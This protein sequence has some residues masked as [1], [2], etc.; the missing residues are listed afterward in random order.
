MG[1]RN[2]S[3]GSRQSLSLIV[4][5]SI[6]LVIICFIGINRCSCSGDTEQKPSQRVS[7][8]GKGNGDTHIGTDEEQPNEIRPSLQ[9]SL[10]RVMNEPQLSTIHANER[11]EDH[12]RILFPEL[13]GA[14]E[15]LGGAKLLGE[16]CA[17]AY[18]NNQ[19]RSKIDVTCRWPQPIDLGIYVDGSEDALPNRINNGEVEVKVSEIDDRGVIDYFMS[20]AIFGLYFTILNQT[21]RDINVT[22]RQGLLLETIGDDIQ[23]I[24][25]RKTVTARLMAYEEQTVRIT[26]YCASHHRGSPVGHMVRIT[27]FYLMASESVFR[28]QESLWQWQEDRYAEYVRW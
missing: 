19:S 22:I 1:F 26:A 4:I 12:F 17:D 20:Y 16:T 7:V 13:D 3:S 10:E 27:P 23:N 2:Y 6:V 15:G 24:V 9:E 14:K 11:Y 18:G 5:V 25:V 8:W 21:N 28:T